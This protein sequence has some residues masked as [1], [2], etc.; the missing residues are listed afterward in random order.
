M[1]RVSGTDPPGIAAAV[2]DAIA[3]DCAG[4][5]GTAADMVAL[6]DPDSPTDGLAAAALLAAGIDGSGAVPLLFAGETL[7]AGTAAR[8]R[9]VPIEIDRQRVHL[10]MLAV[11]G[12]GAVSEA[13]MAEALAAGA[14]SGPFSVT[15]E[16]KA[17]ERAFK[18]T[19]SDGL[20]AA[21]PGAEGH[22]RDLLYVNGVPA[23]LDPTFPLDIVPGEPCAEPRSFLVNLRAPLEAG[24]VVELI[25]T[26]V[27]FGTRGDR[28]LLSGARFVVPELPIDTE[29]PAIEVVAPI[30]AGTVRIAASDDSGPEGLRFDLSRITVL[31]SA[32][33][34]VSVAA[35]FDAEML[36]LFEVTAFDVNLIAPEGYTRQAPGGGVVQVPPGGAYLLQAG[37]RVL[38]RSGSVTDAAGNLSRS[39]RSTVSEPHAPLRPLSVQIVPVPRADGGSATGLAAATFGGALRIAVRAGSELQGTAGNAWEVRFS[40]RGTHDPAAEPAEIDIAVSDRDQL[41][42]IRFASGTPTVGQLVEMLNAHSEF[43]SR[44]EASAVGSCTAQVR[45]V[46]LSHAD[47]NGATTLDGGATQYD[48]TIRFSGP[49]REYLS[50]TPAYADGKQAREFLDDIL[51]GLIDGYTTTASAETAGD[52]IEVEAP[53]PYGRARFRYSTTDTARDATAVRGK[54]TVVGIRAGLARSHHR[55]DPSTDTDESLSVKTRLR[56]EFP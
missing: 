6:T 33:T 14:T 50:D 3:G 48:V 17:G 29:R 12:Y 7:P 27:R 42:S 30:R 4:V 35:E 40:R 26:E 28:R 8:L 23:L 13:A 31:S 1:T 11:G 38:A 39:R 5:L 20:N 18:V 37:D 56:P 24:D 25:P 9:S 16:A 53:A 36:D 22:A 15:L 47:F 43:A 45:P 46:D 44:F 10:R 21:L 51:A 52:A 55:D 2:A 41:V 54:R 32:G 19:L 49:V 34:V